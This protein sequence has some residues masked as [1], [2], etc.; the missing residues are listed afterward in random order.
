MISRLD[1][2]ERSREWGLRD[3]VVE[4]DYVL[5]WVLWGIGGH[6]ALSASWVF[7][8][9]TSLK[10]CYF[11]TYRF[12]E[13]LDFTVL[14][15]GPVHESELAP[16]IGEVLTWIAAESGIDFSQR[17]PIFK[18]SESGDYTEGRIYYRGPR[19]TPT[20]ASVKLD[21]TASE[22]VARPTV[23]RAI[24]HPY[25]DVLPAPAEVQ[26]YAFEEVFAEKIRAMGE[27]CRPRDLYDI[28]HLYRRG[29]F[30]EQPEVV[31]QVLLEKCESKGVPVPTFR[32]ISQSPALA[33]LKS[34]WVNMLA[35]QLQALP[36]FDSFWEELKYLFAWLEESSK[37]GALPSI[38]LGAAEVPSAIWSPP[39]TVSTWGAKVPLETIRF[40]GLNQ[41]CIELGYGGSIRIVEPYSLRK[42]QDGNLVLH[43]VR[44]DSREH[45]SYRVDRIQSVR[46]TGRSFI[47]QYAVE[48]S[49]SGPLFSPSPS[50]SPRRSSGPSTRMR[51]SA[52]TG[53]TYTF[54]CPYCQKR[55]RR[56]RLNARLHEHKSP[57][58]YPCPGRV[59]YL[60]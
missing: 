50:T 2:E 59:G 18:T 30:R 28:V 27:R 46:V 5:G 24:S 21:L 34:E 17:V 3:D 48:F 6:P 1:I 54:Q 12:S 35:H 16:L 33:E 22:K 58:G 13:D 51:R 29:D 11:E 60:V 55:F 37:P 42:T 44:T 57:Q 40:A 53:I 39:A 19:A 9:G 7:K 8:G 56:T 32:S 26:C 23:L 47:P 38:V 45:R 36:P 10:K 41:L 14:P 31:R 20:V 49:A 43:A 52:A 4:K 15:G 25:P